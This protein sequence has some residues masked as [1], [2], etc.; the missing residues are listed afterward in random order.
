MWVKVMFLLKNM[1]CRVQ[2]SQG[3]L[4]LRPRP[5]RGGYGR[6]PWTPRP[7]WQ[8]LAE[9]RV[10]AHHRL[11]ELLHALLKHPVPRAVQPDHGTRV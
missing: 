9:N 1:S 11:T 5:R 3:L 10:H 7:V 6:P 2:N 8:I 4:G